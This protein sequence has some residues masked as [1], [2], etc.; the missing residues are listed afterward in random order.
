[1]PSDRTRHIILSA[2]FI[3]LGTVFPI[4]FHMAGLGKIMLPMFWPVTMAG[5]FVAAP[6]A[7]LTGLLTPFIS[8][9]LTGMPPM[10]ALQLMMAELTV[11]ALAVQ[12]MRSRTRL[13]GVWIVLLAL[14]AS[15]MISFLAARLVAGLLG[16]PPDVYAAGRLISGMPG[17][18]AILILVPLILKRFFSF[19]L[20]IRSSRVRRPS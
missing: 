3:A 2:L 11:L 5:F 6:F 20:F 10:P 8:F 19:P 4:L 15:R 12:L 14:F 7:A 17:I 18:L 9:L 16:W 13:G 1:M